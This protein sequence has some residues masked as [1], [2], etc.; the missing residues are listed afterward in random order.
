MTNASPA[1][2][3]GAAVLL[4]AL[5][6]APQA[7]RA[8]IYKCPQANGT[9]GYQGGKGSTLHPV[10]AAS[11][12]QPATDTSRL[13]ANVQ[14]R[15]RRET[16]QQAWQDAHRHDATPRS[17]AAC[18]SARYNLGVLKEQRPVYTTDN[19]GNRVYVEDKD[20]AATIAATERRI[21]ENCN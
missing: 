13:I 17:L 5:A 6:A 8:Q 21:A 12:A 18:N 20:R 7:A 14:E 1:W 9:I 11:G 10:E 3:V 4:G 15:N 19:K 2:A 16:E